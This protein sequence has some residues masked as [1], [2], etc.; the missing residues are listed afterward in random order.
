MT[1]LWNFG[2]GVHPPENKSQ[3][4]SRPIRPAGLPEKLTL[5]LQ[6]HIGEP[7]H[8]IVKP[9]QTVLKGEVIAQVGDGMG[10]PVHAPTSG[11][12][13][14]ISLEPVPHPSGM[15]DTCV[16]LIPDG[17]ERWCELVPQ[18]EYRKLERDQVLALIRQAGIVGLGGAGFPTNI[19]LQPS[20]EREINTLILNGAECEPYITADDMT[21]REKADQV[22]A[23]LRI[24]A[25]LLR[26]ARVIIGV[27]E[28]KPEAI[29]ALRQ[30]AE[31]STTEIAVIPTLYPSGGEK[32]LIQILTGQEVPSAGVPADIG[33]MCQNIGTAVAVADA[34]LQGKPLIARVM[35]ATGEAL[36]E[37]GNFEV[38]V[39]TPASHLLTCAGVDEQRMSRLVLGG[40]MMGYTLPNMDIPLTKNSNC[41]IAA[42]ASELPAPA[43][44]QPCIRCG[45]CADACPMALLPQQLFWHA[46]AT[47][48]DKAEHL[49]LF[50]CIEC[51]ACS[52]VCPSSIPLVQYYRF[53]KGE[54]RLQRAEQQK[55]DRARVR[56]EARQQRLTREQQE[57]D[58]RRKDRALAATNA[59][60][61]KTA[62][63][64]QKVQ[65][66]TVNDK[67]A[68]KSALV[69]QALAR[70]KAKA[71]AASAERTEPSTPL[72][73]AAAP[74]ETLAPKHAD[75]IP[76]AETAPSV[77][78]LEQQLTQAQAKLANMQSMLEDA[79]SGQAPNVDKLEGA[80][81]T[82]IERVRRA[83]QAIDHAQQQAVPANR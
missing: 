13:K 74:A 57:K 34:I 61:Q 7:A 44:E 72:F 19:K 30:A 65:D 69:E 28:N 25:W 18:P 20:A 42:S 68:G 33:V 27:E 45:Q 41:V 64:H 79:H 29:A 36:T 40:S 82:N 12:V 55:S 81:D 31:D 1:Q 62:D 24:M 15:N 2:G 51:G 3:S 21:M 22:M 80:V 56:F 35:T 50:D 39:G 46:K 37:P 43:P 11:I 38:L 4:N 10:V 16:V 66:G 32:Q 17:E 23:G 67:R 49:N 48:F 53:A 59:Q 63:A 58:Q 26:P 14:R 78:E 73:E 54:I 71:A 77:A 8:C 76:A 52:Y 47:E 60:E 5:P 70:K 9:G 75:R 6:Q 83:Q